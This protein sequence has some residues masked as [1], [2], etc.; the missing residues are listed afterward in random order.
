ME[1]IIIRYTHFMGILS[2]ASILTTQ[3]V[4][5]LYLPNMVSHKRLVI[6]DAL[7]GLSAIVVLASGLTLWFAV[8]KP[9]EFYSQNGIFHFK[10]TLFFCIALLS[11]YPTI[12]FIK[13]RKCSNVREIPNAVIICKRLEMFLLVVMPLCAVLMARGVG[14]YA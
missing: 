9:Q 11:L 2:L 12:Y 13:N 10:V 8:G 3:N 7:Y 14:Y 5:L 1:E 6:I 4:L